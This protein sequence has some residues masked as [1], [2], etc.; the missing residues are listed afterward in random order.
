[1]S[2]SLFGTRIRALR[3]ER[4][5][6]QEDLAERLGFKDRQTLSAIETGER[7]LSAEE[8]L[9]AAKVLGA[10]LETFTDPFLLIGEGRFSWRQTG[11]MPA[12]LVDYE[13]DAGRWIAAYRALAAEQGHRPPLDRRS[14]RLSKASRFEDAVAAG[15]R[16]AAEYELGDVP[17]E[18]LASVMQEAF[19]ILV[20]MVDAIAGVSGAACRLPELDTVLINR[21][22]IV[23]RRH[24]DLAH[25]MF[26]ILTWD[27][28]PPDHIEASSER[29]NNRVEQLANNFASAVLMPGNV[30]AR[31]GGWTEIAGD[32]LVEKL[33]E[34]ADALT[35]T[36]S[37]LKWRLVAAGQ[38]SVAV[39]KSIDDA[40]VRNNGHSVP[41]RGS[42]RSLGRRDFERDEMPLIGLLTTQPDEVRGEDAATGDLSPLFSKPFLQVIARALSEGE[43][44]VRRAA[45]LLDLTIDDLPDLFAAHAIPAEIGV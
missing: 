26:H 4:K 17:A 32:G 36:A 8:L 45:G 38:L 20:L 10:S 13:R 11:V 12:R 40:L 37:A 31:F 44:S 33:N 39:A 29:S 1:M 34:T 42:A 15:E 18:R 28:M 14:L 43:L 2:T 30:L 27:T 23:G 5:L 22:E 41:S 9:L 21:R 19:G 3:E 16:F 6:T 35:V 7:R 25:E 24:Y